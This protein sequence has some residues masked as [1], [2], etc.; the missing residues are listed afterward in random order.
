M[1]NVFLCFSQQPLVVSQS[2]STSTSHADQVYEVVLCQNDV[3]VTSGDGVIFFGK[4][5]AC[6]FCFFLKVH[7]AIGSVISLL[8]STFS[9]DA[10]VNIHC[11][12]ENFEKQL[13]VRW[14]SVA[15]TRWSRSTRLLCLTT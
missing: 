4:F 3:A 5:N 14:F 11:G 15:V 13:V 8:D 10:M 2:F 12:T 1:L 9:E 7:C 6:L